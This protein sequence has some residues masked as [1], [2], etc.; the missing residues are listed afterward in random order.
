[1][2][3]NWF[4]D[5]LNPRQRAKVFAF[6]VTRYGEIWWCYPRGDATECTHAVIYN[7]RENSWYDT[8]LPLSGRAS[9]EFNNGFAAPLLTDAIPAESGYRVWIHEQGTDAIEGIRTEPVLSYF[10]TADLSS[11]VQGADSR[12]RVDVVE[13]DFIQSGPMTMQVMGRANARAPEQASA[14]FTF[15]DTAASPRDQ[16]LLLKETRRELRFRFQS[17]AVGGDYQMGQVIGHVGP[18][19]KTQLS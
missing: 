2:N 13:P 1:M 9:G 12:L 18:G 15:Q 8:E 17:N 5:G 3:L 7:V 6:R 10:E 16:L 4:F 19:D 14:M 11:L